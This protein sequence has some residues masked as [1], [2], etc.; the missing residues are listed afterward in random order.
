MAIF[1]WDVKDGVAVVTLDT[2]GAS[3]NVISRTVKEEMYEMLAALERDASVK[4]VAFFSGKPDNFI[5]GAD[6]EE[7]VQ[8][9]SAA[10]A[11]QLARDG[12]ALLDRVATFPKPIVAGI[13]GA[14]LGGGL[15]FALACR[16]RVA[17]D[18][19]KTQLGLPEIQLGIL[20]A[21]GGCQRLPRLIGARAALDIILA[22]KSERGA[23]AFR[24]GIVDE[25]V[26]PSILQEISIAAARRLAQ[27]PFRRRRK[28]GFL[29]V[30]LDG[31]PIGRL[32]VFYLAR[33][34]VLAQTK[35]NYPAPLAALEAV[36]HGLSHGMREGL[37]R[38]ALLF[39]QLTLSDVSRKLVQIFFATRELKKDLGVPGAPAPAEV[40]RLA[41]VG[42]GFMGAGIAGTTVVQVGI[43]V[44]LKDADLGRVA[45]GL[46][47]A[48]DL[49][50]ERL[51]RRRITKFE[52]ARLVAFLSGSDQYTGFGGAE[53]VIEAVFEELGVKQQVLRECEAVLPA[54]AVF[55]SN[56][57][58]IPIG[59]I[60][61]ASRRPEQ[62]IG[63]HFFS[64]VARMPLLE[65]IPTAATAP[66][67]VST[68]VGFGRRL[69]KTVIVV[70]DAP[71]FWVNRI[72]GPYMNEAAHLLLSGVSPE[73]I[74]RAMVQFGFPVGPITL[75]DEVGID[76]A[77]HAGEVLQAAFGE[78]LTPPAALAALVK[79]GRLGR[80]AGKGFY[81]YS[82]G[83]KGGVDPAIYPLLGVQPNGGIP[84]AEIVQR[85]TF[86][87]L[88]EAARAAAEGVVRSPRDGDIGA[89]YGFG[90][91][92]F[93][94]GPLRYLDDLGADRL[95]AE[96]QRLAERLGPRFMPSEAIVEQARAR[97]R[98][99]P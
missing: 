74:D 86:A 29:G 80:K 82:D 47:A 78:R 16:Y 2:P 72:L 54:G 35:G 81:T 31:N 18:H 90:F 83:K 65:V 71:G 70:K 1:T 30:L 76:V 69:G 24:L 55:A 59:R 95:F 27:A 33:K 61:D 4:A 67:T 6:I 5:A 44:R 13:H 60:A 21:A 41:V 20:P 23:K 85:L 52:H 97:A 39:G 68:A 11:E 91:P 25:L 62:V 36:R 96:L 56:T 26:P 48:R 32:L 40:H 57:S 49:V 37:R 79:D 34:Q 87:M 58:T 22:G 92:P 7:F 99:Y 98:F 75:L 73:E 12:Q 53:L 42:S 45:K 46:A 93:R 9:K 66:Q 19:P 8:L 43:D 3:V 38:E 28:T 63:M 10:D 94:G 50:N 17:T 15:E 51:S 89:I 14:C 88:N 84:T 77:Q 64:P